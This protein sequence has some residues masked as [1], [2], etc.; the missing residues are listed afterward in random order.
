MSLNPVALD[1]IRQLGGDSLARQIVALFRRNAPAWIEAADAALAAGDLKSVERA[2]HSLRSS[3]GNL[4]ATRLSELAAEAEELAAIG[5]GERLAGLVA[6]LG[7]AYA[8]VEP[9]LPPGEG[10]GADR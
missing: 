8:E 3:A 10:E 2:C 7:E 4:G 1:R 6:A 9:R 5:G